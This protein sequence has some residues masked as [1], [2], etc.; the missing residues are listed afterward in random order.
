VIEDFTDFRTIVDE[1]NEP[2]LPNTLQAQQWKNN[3]FQLYSG[4]APT[5]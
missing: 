2:H 3:D 5:G 1:G 4:N